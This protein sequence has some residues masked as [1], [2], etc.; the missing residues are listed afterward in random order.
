MVGGAFPNA[1]DRDR[2]T[3][4]QVPA[5][6]G[7]EDVVFV[8]LRTTC[9]GSKDDAE[10]FDGF[11]PLMFESERVISQR[12]TLPHSGSTFSAIIIGARPI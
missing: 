2:F 3:L 6:L 4:L 5:S 12:P 1:C 10:S 8:L 11:S 9:A 7:R